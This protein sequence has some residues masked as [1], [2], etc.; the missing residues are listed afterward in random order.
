[1]TPTL[2]GVLDPSHA[3][4]RRGLRLAR[5]A[6][7]FLERSN[8]GRLAGLSRC[9]PAGAAHPEGRSAAEDGEAVALLPPVRD[10]GT[11]QL[12]VSVRVLM[13]VVLRGLL[14]TPHVMSHAALVGRACRDAK[15]AARAFGVPSRAFVAPRDDGQLSVRLREYRR[16]AGRGQRR[17]AMLKRVRRAA[18]ER[19]GW[20]MVFGT[21]TVAPGH[22]ESVFGRGSREWQKYAQRVRRACAPWRAEHVAVVERGGV[23]SRLH[24]HVVWFLERPPESWCSRVA[25]GA[26]LRIPDASFL[27]PHGWSSHYPVRSGSDYWSTVRG[28][29]GRMRGSWEAVIGYVAKYMNCGASEGGVVWRTRVTRSLGQE[30]IRR[31]L[32]KSRRWSR[33][34]VEYPRLLMVR[35]PAEWRL[36]PAEMRR[37]AL[38]VWREQKWRPPNRWL[39]SWA[40][41]W[42]GES[43]ETCSVRSLLALARSGIRRCGTSH[44]RREGLVSERFVDECHGKLWQRGVESGRM[45]EALT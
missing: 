39:R 42:K 4:A 38:R 29:G 31:V 44:S 28:W 10:A 23:G 27:W 11:S 7:S 40:S 35:W 36:P 41:A 26:P 30:R 43:P 32:A 20:A 22:M 21:L 3:A 16:S 6:V 34:A 18:R 14:D 8:P 13:Y 2:C 25:A 19:R 24:V 9:A 17:S 37:L 15:A 45:L 5:R 33:M 1:M 12:A